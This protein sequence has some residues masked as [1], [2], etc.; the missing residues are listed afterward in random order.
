MSES[1]TL[2]ACCFCTRGL[3]PSWPFCPWC[4][5]AQRTPSRP[6]EPCHDCDPCSVGQRCVITG[7]TSAEARPA[8]A[9][10]EAARELLEAD[11]ALWGY[12]ASHTDMTG[13]GWQSLRDRFDARLAALRAALAQDG[14][15]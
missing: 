5:W 7:T 4:G 15:G 11:E 9:V 10:R 13:T 2:V 14:R 1:K 8:D 12:A 6:I 3:E